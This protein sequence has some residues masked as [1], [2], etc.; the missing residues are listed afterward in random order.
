MP[1]VVLKASGAVAAGQVVKA[2]ETALDLSTAISGAAPVN[3]L[4][5]SWPLGGVGTLR[6]R[7]GAGAGSFQLTMMAADTPGLT[8]PIRLQIAG[9]GDYLWP[10][11]RKALALNLARLSTTVAPGG[12]ITPTLLQTKG[13]V[14]GDGAV[15]VLGI[16]NASAADGET[17]Q[18]TT[19][20]PALTTCSGGWLTGDVL[21]SAAAGK[22]RKLGMGET[23]VDRVAYA[24]SDQVDGDTGCPVNV[25]LALV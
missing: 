15:G 21:S 23:G 4:I 9:P 18:A 14:A 25:D 7:V 17:F 24:L 12:T 1:I 13:I 16:A 10:T 11:S 20:G 8:R 5:T 6:I 19:F 22:M 2:Q 3:K